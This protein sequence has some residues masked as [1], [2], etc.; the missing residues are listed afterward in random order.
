MPPAAKARARKELSK[1]DKIAEL[2]FALSKQEA[3][4]TKMAQQLSFLK[5]VCF[6]PRVT[7]RL[8]ERGR[9]VHCVD[10]LRM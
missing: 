8:V 9:A 7:W 6:S 5:Q 2:E 10:L 4:E 1:D 3:K